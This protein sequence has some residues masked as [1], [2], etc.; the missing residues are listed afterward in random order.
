M[1]VK[2]IYMC[3]DK[4]L[5]I[6]IGN[7]PVALYARGRVKFKYKFKRIKPYGSKALE[8]WEN[9]GRSAPIVGQ[10]FAVLVFKDQN[11][12]KIVFK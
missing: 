2:E 11:D 7:R 3:I 4:Y 9:S 8:N 12:T 5:I 1:L 6:Y 10:R